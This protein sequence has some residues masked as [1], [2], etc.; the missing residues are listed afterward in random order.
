MSKVRGRWWS[1]YSA[2]SRSDRF[3]VNTGVF[4]VSIQLRVVLPILGF[5]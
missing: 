2:V 4:E 3:S 1:D 5:R